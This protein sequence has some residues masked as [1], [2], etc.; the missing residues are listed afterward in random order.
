MNKQDVGKALSSSDPIDRATVEATALA[1]GGELIAEIVAE[2]REDAAGR[3]A[4]L[5]RRR[6]FAAGG[7]IAGRR[8]PRVVATGLACI[9]CGGTAMAATGVWDPPIGSKAP[10]SGPVITSTTPVPAAVTEALGVL[11]RPASD[12]DHGPEVEA[13]LS[14]LGSRYLSDRMPGLDVSFHLR[15]I[16]PESVRYLEPGVDGEATI[17]FSAENSW[18]GLGETQASDFEI[19]VL[20]DAGV[21]GTGDAVCVARSI[22]DRRPRS[23]LEGV[24]EC[25]TL[26]S[27]LTG[28]AVWQTE[29]MNA[30]GEAFGLVPDGVASITAEFASGAKRTVPV[31]DNYFRFNWD[32]AEAAI[33]DEEIEAGIPVGPGVITWHDA[34]GSVVSEQSSN[35]PGDEG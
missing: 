17:L 31:T 4:A 7:K 27:I 29:L 25:F 34:N 10:D 3:S 33:T 15:G 16:R 20:R 1:V 28:R 24:P 19:G 14:T 2:P 8:T 30:P 18:F 35:E 6:P 13:T 12:L 5:R 32:A 11:R 22:G 26:D 9:A 23:S 21:L